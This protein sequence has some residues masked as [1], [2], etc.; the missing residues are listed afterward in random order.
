MKRFNEVAYDPTTKTATI[1]AGQTWNNVYKELNEKHKVN[2]LGARVS[3]IGVAGFLLGGGEYRFWF[4]GPTFSDNVKP[5][6][7]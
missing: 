6:Y 2:V 5:Y 4:W 1:G 7:S 3:N